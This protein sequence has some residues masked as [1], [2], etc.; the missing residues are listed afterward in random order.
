MTPNDKLRRIYNCVLNAQIH[1]V[2]DVTPLEDIPLYQD[3]LRE[4]EALCP[5]VRAVQFKSVAMTS[6]V[7][8][9][10][11]DCQFFG[12]PLEQEQARIQQEKRERKAESVTVIRKDGTVILCE[13]GHLKAASWK[14]TGPSGRKW[15]TPHLYPW[16]NWQ[17]IEPAARAWLHRLGITLEEGEWVVCPSDLTL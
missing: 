4:V 12:E 16:A 7:H 10:D 17:G 5:R 15:R 6:D 9:C 1:F 2:F 8:E 14:L 13:G 3:L 11:E